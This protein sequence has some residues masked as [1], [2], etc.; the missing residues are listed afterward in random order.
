M[1]DEQ[2]DRSRRKPAAEGIAAMPIA[3]Y[4]WKTAVRWLPT[5]FRLT[6]ELLHS[7]MGALAVT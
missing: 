2:A 4:L 7:T 5:L 3:L 6:V 1:G